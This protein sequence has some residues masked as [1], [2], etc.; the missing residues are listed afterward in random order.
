MCKGQSNHRAPVPLGVERLE[1]VNR[2]GEVPLRYPQ[3]IGPHNPLTAYA[4]EIFMHIGGGRH[5]TRSEKMH[6]NKTSLPFELYSRFW[7]KTT[8][9]TE[10]SLPFWGVRMYTLDL[11]LIHI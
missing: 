6:N 1:A 11:S 9:R 8:S 3:L 7:G 10:K 5:T 2:T 4:C